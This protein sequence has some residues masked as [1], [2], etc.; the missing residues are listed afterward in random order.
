M[1][2]FIIKGLD[3]IE[4]DMSIPYESKRPLL[5]NFHKNLSN[6]GWN[7]TGNDVNEKDRM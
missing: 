6:K 5:L 4:D 7:F 3:T 2:F 1:F